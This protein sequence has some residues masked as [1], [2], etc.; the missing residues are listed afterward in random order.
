MIAGDTVRTYVVDTVNRVRERIGLHFHSE[1]GPPLRAELFSADQMEQYGAV[2]AAS[3]QLTKRRGPDHL[4]ARLADNESTLRS[5]CGVLTVA[6]TANH[7]LTPA[8]EWLLDN[9]Y[10]IQEQIR[11]AKRHLPKGYSRQLPR[12]ERGSSAGL[13]RVYDIAL[14]T[15]AHGD[16]RIDIESL[17]RFVASYQTVST[18]QLGE[19]WAIPIMLRGSDRESAPRRRQRRVGEEKIA[20]LPIAGLTK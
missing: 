7:Q 16:G 3:H 6:V 17:S 11:T 8:G 12:L 2:L 10:L 9:L 4:L 15:I 1:D 18:L 13:P 20:I 19:L 14:Q 5:I